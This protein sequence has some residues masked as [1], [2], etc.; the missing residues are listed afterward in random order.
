MRGAEGA[1]AAPGGVGARGV[2]AQGGGAGRAEGFCQGSASEAS[3]R[4]A[5]AGRAG[6]P[7]GRGQRGDEEE[8]AARVPAGVQRAGGGGRGRQPAGAGLPGEPERDR[9]PGA[10][11]GR[12]RGA[13]GGWG[14]GSGSG[15]QRPRVGGRGGGAR[16][17]RH[18]PA[19]GDGRGG[20]P[21]AARLPPG[22]GG[23]ASGEGAEGGVDQGDAGEAGRGGEPQALP[24]AQAHG[25]AGVRGG[26][27]GDGVPS[28]P[29]ARPREGGG[30]VVPGDVGVQLQAAA[31]PQGGVNRGWKP[32]RNPDPGLL[33][34]TGAALATTSQTSCAGCAAIPRP[35]AAVREPGKRILHT[36]HQ[37]ATFAAKVRQAARGVCSG[38][39]SS[40]ELPPQ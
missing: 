17:S 6:Q 7:D 15:G 23:G 2:R 20:R 19:G 34:S 11:C 4:E 30:R 28:V 26:E 32:P 27:A 31:Q 33:P 38:G 13:G 37:H 22:A 18:G 9:P 21:A 3:E 14:A 25:G 5:E 35:D 36:S 10:G 40:V 29:A 12:G 39:E 24:G 16:G 1:G 8:R